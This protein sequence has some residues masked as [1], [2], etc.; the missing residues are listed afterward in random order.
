[1]GDE[2]KEWYYAYQNESRGPFTVEEMRTLI[3]T[4]KINAITR[5]WKEG[6][7]KWVRCSE[8][9]LM[10]PVEEKTSHRVMNIIFIVLFLLVLIGAI[11]FTYSQVV[12][13]WSNQYSVVG[14]IV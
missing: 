6:S 12:H 8:S 7:K 5:V 1:M 4:K 2:R 13:Y 9:G 11:Y 14:M 10:I 3:Q